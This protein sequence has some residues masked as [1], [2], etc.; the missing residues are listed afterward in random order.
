MNLAFSFLSGFIS[1]CIGISLPGLINMTA[2]KVSIKDG[3][4][5]AILFA[6]FIDGNPEV[7]V[8]LRE[9]GF[10]IF[11]ALT[12]YFLLIAKAPKAKKEEVKIRSKTNRFFLGMLLSALN[13]FPIPYYVFVTMTAASYN[14]FWFEKLPISL[15]LIGVVLGS[16]AVFYY[17][18]SF[19]KKIEAKTDFFFKNMN[20][21]IG[22]VT[23]I[24][25]LIT[26]VNI[27]KY[28]F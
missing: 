5:R 19:F 26:L 2:A 3:K 23:G 25:A 27:L 28:Y 12:I 6:R 7:I 9:V 1:A 8:L 11:V 18:I 20:T 10:A 21:I 22:S 14:F 24:I 4:D 15:F 17:Y 13:F 16:F